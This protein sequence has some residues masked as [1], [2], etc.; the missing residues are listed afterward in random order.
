MATAGLFGSRS[1]HGTRN[2]RSHRSSKASTRSKKRREDAEV[3]EVK[4]PG[5]DELRQKRAIYYNASPTEQKK[6]SSVSTV[7]TESKRSTSSTLRSTRATEHRH[8]KGKHKTNSSKAVDKTLSESQ[9]RTE[10]YVYGPR[11]SV[12]SEPA[13]PGPAKDDYERPRPE[14]RRPKHSRSS[15]RH[16]LPT[17]VESEITPDDSISQVAE[18]EISERR[19]EKAHIRP[20]LRRSSTTSSKLPPVSEVP[21]D[22]ESVATTKRPSKR[23]STVTGAFVRRHTTTSVPT[24]PRLVE[25]LTCG[26]DDVPSAQSAKLACSHRMCHDCLKR[27][28]EMSVKDPAH[29]PPKCCTDQHIPLKHVDK[30]FDLKFKMLWNRK[31]Q[32]YHTKDR[33]YCPTLKCGEWIK[34]SHICTLQGRKV[35]ICPR[36]KTK[37]CTMCN[38]K[39]H[40]STECPKDPEIAKL[41]EQAK[42][43]G[44]QRCYSCSAFVEKKEGCNHITCRC[45]AEFCII[46][47]AQWKT[48]DCA[49]F[50]Y[51]HLPNPDRLNDMRVPEP[52]Q[53]IYR[54]VLRAAANPGAP[55]PAQQPPPPEPARPR[56]SRHE[57]LPEVTYQQELDRRRRQEREDAELA[58]RLQLASLM[59]ENVDERPARRRAPAADV[60]GLGM[61]ARHFMNDDF[62]Q[63]A[64]NVVM[65]AF[66]DIDMGRRGERP[67]ARRRRAR[68]VAQNDGDPGLV[69]DF[70][71]DDSVPQV[72]RAGRP[73]RTPGS[74]HSFS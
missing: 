70:L 59:E 42:E 31:Y 26:A 58:R 6:I 21:G 49:W 52:I 22:S 4:K 39:M 64:A 54:Q 48:C 60:W 20:S 9:K 16:S 45:M 15:H 27:I 63:N 25:C 24:P 5:L 40:K 62:V 14:H 46:C 56:N 2:V 71:N 34:P 28:F 12:E 67:S 1:R 36:C 72:G 61:A 30:L 68:N 23:D 51:T 8:G 65:D 43:Q 41:V 66:G 17:V 44:W 74:R 47:G 37:V 50:E 33:I 18:M 32:E 57:P 7:K 38:N 29:M 10:D 69:P 13:I 55:L 73:E 53:F 19:K 3:E 35:A 11:V